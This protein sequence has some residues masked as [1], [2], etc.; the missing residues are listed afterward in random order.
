MRDCFKLLLTL[1]AAGQSLLAAPLA[2]AGENDCAALKTL[3]LSDV[4]IAAAEDISGNEFWPYPHSVF[5]SMAGPNPGTDVAFCRVAG[6]IEKEIT[7]EV[8]L[9]KDW[10]E[11]FQ[12]VGNGGFSGGLNYPAMNLAA[13]RGFATALPRSCGSLLLKGSW[14]LRKL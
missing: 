14:P 10:N 13:G 12:A 9:P 1:F 5:N 4:R 2:S 6:V 3:E 7:F 8:W 11:R